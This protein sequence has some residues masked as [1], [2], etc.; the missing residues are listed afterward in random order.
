MIVKMK[1]LKLL[2]PTIVSLMLNACSMNNILVSPEQKALEDKEHLARYQEVLTELKT[3][4]SPPIDDT[5]NIVTAED[6]QASQNR[7]GGSSSAYDDSSDSSSSSSSNASSS[8]SN[9]GSDYNSQKNVHDRQ[10]F[11]DELNK[12]F[13]EA[14]AAEARGDTRAARELMKKAEASAYLYRE[15][16]GR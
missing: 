10:Y 5:Y 3:I 12:S 15:A 13:G 9:S 1:A 8:S 6:Y 11:S 7:A 14:K 2:F 4:K 16:G